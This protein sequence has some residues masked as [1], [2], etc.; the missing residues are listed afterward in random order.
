M[1]PRRRQTLFALAGSALA[2]PLSSLAQHV[3]NSYRIAFLSPEAVSDPNQTNRLEALRSGLRDLGYVEGRNLGIESRWAEGRYEQLAEMAAGLVAIKVDVI[4]TAGTKATLAAARAT[5]SIP[6]VVGG[7]DI[8]GVGLSTNL[9]RPSGN[10][11]GW[12]NFAPEVTRKLLELMKEAA[13]RVTHVAYL[14][15]PADPTTNMPAM[16]STAASL[17]FRL[18][19][20]EARAPGELVKVF[21]EIERARCDAVLVQGDTMFAAN[22]RAVADLAL[23]HRLVSASAI[24]EY[25]DAGGLISYG[26]DRLEGYRRAAG[27][28]DKL[29]KGAKP[30]DLPIQQATQ[31]EFFINMATAKSLGLT[32]PQTLQTRARLVQ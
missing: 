26:P 28:V 7:G 15:N 20:L 10:V 19:V 29:L 12:M 31:F 8:V 27:F 13:P 1:K 5:T 30:G 23:R 3:R 32:I 24:N 2:M 4:V 11:T 21:A 18:S 9:A 25:A 14:A 6:I 17:K 16:Q 22:A